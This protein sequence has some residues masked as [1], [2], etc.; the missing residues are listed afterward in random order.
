MWHILLSPERILFKRIIIYFTPFVAQ[1]MG[2]MTSYCW[3]VFTADEFN[4]CGSDEEDAEEDDEPQDEVNDDGERHESKVD[5]VPRRFSNVKTKTKPIPPE[6]SLFIFR[7]T[8][9]YIHL[10]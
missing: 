10:Y 1:S 8:N 7:S 4:S 3:N 5:T 9:R 6:I 2:S